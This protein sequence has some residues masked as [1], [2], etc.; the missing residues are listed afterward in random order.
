MCMKNINATLNLFA[1]YR[2][3]GDATSFSV[4]FDT[5][6]CNISENIPYISNF[7]IVSNFCLMGTTQEECKE[8]NVVEKR[9]KLYCLVRLTKLSTDPDKRY[10]WDVKE[11]VINTD[12]NDLRFEGACVPC[13]NFRSTIS[14]RSVKLI[15]DDYLGDYAL[16][17]LVRERED[18]K[19]QPQSIMKL[20]VI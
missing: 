8:E 12:D 15:S 4:P 17:I 13:V 20:T 14:I 16:K 9:G 3:D 10:S 11:F 18:D 19:W 5:I 6:K 7:H 2:T 1:N